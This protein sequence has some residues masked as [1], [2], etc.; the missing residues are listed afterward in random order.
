MSKTCSFN[1][2][3][4]LKILAKVFNFL[5]FLFQKPLQISE[6]VPLFAM[7]QSLRKKHSMTSILTN[8]MQD[9]A[10]VIFKNKINN[11]DPRLLKTPFVTQKNPNSTLLHS[12]R[13]KCKYFSWE[14]SSF[15]GPEPLR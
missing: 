6:A 11:V 10:H 5:K 1:S 9:T 7:N 15:I 13:H 3:C 14:I 2:N 8:Q 4:L 12:Q